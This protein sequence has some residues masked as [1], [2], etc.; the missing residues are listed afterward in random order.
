MR[1][2]STSHSEP[3]GFIDHGCVHRKTASDS[4]PTANSRYASAFRDAIF[5]KIKSRL[6]SN[7]IATDRLLPQHLPYCLPANVDQFAWDSLLLKPICVPDS[8]LKTMFRLEVDAGTHGPINKS[9]GRMFY[10]RTY[11]LLVS[12]LQ[13]VIADWEA[14]DH[15][16]EEADTWINMMAALRSNDT[17]YLRYIGATEKT[18]PHQ[19]L[20]N[21]LISRSS[22]FVAR[23]HET[24]H[25]LFPVALDTSVVYKF[26]EAR[27][28]KDDLLIKSNHDLPEQALIALFGLS[29]LLNQTVGGFSYTYALNDQQRSRFEA[30]KTNT[31]STMMIELQ[32]VSQGMK[33]ALR[34]WVEHISSYAKEHKLSVTSGHPFP[35]S[36]RDVVLKQA[37]P[38]L[39]RGVTTLFVTVGS[40]ISMACFLGNEPFYNGSS[41]AACLIKDFFLRLHKWER[42]HC[43]ESR[44]PLNDLIEAGG[45]P[46]VDLC[47]WLKAEGP[48]LLAA[49]GF[50]RSYLAI[51]QPLVVLTLSK[52]PSSVAASNFT[53]PWGYPDRDRF[54]RKVGTLR[55][56]YY[57]GYCSI[58]IPCFHPG[59]VR[60][61]KKPHL[62]YAVLDMTLWIL[63]LTIHTISGMQE[64]L[65][66]T[67]RDSFC[68]NVKA[69]V[70]QVLHTV[71]IDTLLYKVN[72]ELQA[73]QTNNRV[74]YHA[75]GPKSLIIPKAKTRIFIA[76]SR[77]VVSAENS[78]VLL[79]TETIRIEHF[80]ANLL[81]GPLTQRKGGN[82]CPGYGI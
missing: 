45:M 54:W 58:Q 18:N 51:V 66:N 69:H 76:S 44:H 20:L 40:G 29:S 21:D 36:L 73:G 3:T 7:G 38:S 31:F 74:N 70:E 6:V 34:E 25:R 65:T 13:D 14:N 77:I 50:L 68:C 9:N 72:E 15:Y 4:L 82:N 2:R 81:L 32:P 56:V 43:F 12:Q 27:P 57:S 55:L 64:S 16:H 8:V 35:D 63:L 60:Y 5:R 71:G 59:Q 37:T 67:S 11:S 52:T 26:S 47:P 22:G 24:V 39:F 75:K 62:F 49:I 46:F 10:L 30:L 23:F 61:M 41:P 19:R 17:V 33:G 78:E 42:S 48:D 53:H 28:M 1:Q 80:S 79:L